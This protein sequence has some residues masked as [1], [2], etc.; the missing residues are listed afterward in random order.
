MLTDIC[1]ERYVIGLKIDRNINNA[2]LVS[3][4]TKHVF[5]HHHT[6]TD[7]ENHLIN[8]QI[9]V[10]IVKKCLKSEDA[11]TDWNCI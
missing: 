2:H 6:D 5:C 10:R 4:Q 3:A 1:F 9:N 8:E 7:H 11:V